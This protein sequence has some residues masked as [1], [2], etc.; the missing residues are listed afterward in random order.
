MLSL[1]SEMIS[2]LSADS[3][4]FSPICSTFARGLV[5]TFYDT[6][7]LPSVSL[8][9]FFLN[10][11]FLHTSLRLVSGASLHHRVLLSLPA[12]GRASSRSSATVR[13]LASR[14]GT[15]ELTAGFCYVVDGITRQLAC[16]AVHLSQV[17]LT[18]R[19]V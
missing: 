15:S 2:N 10:V 13:T 12:S 4:Q 5:G 16:A 7:L 14:A 3:L 19:G 8:K 1:I 6:G 17:S 11:N 18:A 9:Y